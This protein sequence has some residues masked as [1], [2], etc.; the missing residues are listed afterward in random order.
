MA[1]LLVLEFSG[2]DGEKLYKKV[3]K[4]LDL[5]SGW[6]D[7]IISHVAGVSGDKFI[8]TE[9]WKSREDQ[10]AFMN[11]R[12][13]IALSDAGAPAPHRIEW[14]SGIGDHHS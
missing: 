5:D 4:S 3:N 7:G 2:A 1:E 14:F 8:V 12:L 10:E 13:G 6:P 11:S 9:T